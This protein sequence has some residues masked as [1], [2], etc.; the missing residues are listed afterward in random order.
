[1]SGGEEKENSWKG[2]ERENVNEVGGV[3][4]FIREGVGSPAEFCDAADLKE[5][6]EDEGETVKYFSFKKN[7]SLS[8]GAHFAP[9]NCAGIILPSTHLRLGLLTSWRC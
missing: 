9:V 2:R 5:T 4:V 1:M 7:I 8:F 3:D 6:D